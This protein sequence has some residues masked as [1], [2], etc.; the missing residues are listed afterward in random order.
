MFRARGLGLSSKGV[1]CM[2]V[3]FSLTRGGEQCPKTVPLRKNWNQKHDH[4]SH[5]INLRPTKNVVLRNMAFDY[6]YN[7]TLSDFIRC[8]QRRHITC[9]YILG[10]DRVR[11]FKPDRTGLDQD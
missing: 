4:I 11:N 9:V 5:E 6:T 1:Y 10:A 8:E 3:H 2:L 7:A